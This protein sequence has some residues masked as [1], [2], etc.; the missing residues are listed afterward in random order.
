[1]LFG[2]FLAHFGREKNLS[3][4]ERT[5]ALKVLRQLLCES[6][7][8]MKIDLTTI[9]ITF[10]RLSGGKRSIPTCSSDISCRVWLISDQIKCFCNALI[11]LKS[12]ETWYGMRYC[13]ISVK[14]YTLSWVEGEAPFSHWVLCIIISKTCLFPSYKLLITINKYN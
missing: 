10:K 2:I 11:A 5:V 9:I 7:L 8:E 6:G 1:M 3:S 13:R 4:A 14:C 12:T